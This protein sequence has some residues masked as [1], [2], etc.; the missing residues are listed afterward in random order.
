M[1]K[2]NLTLSMFA[3]A[4]SVA[5]AQTKS[6]TFK[7]LAAKGTNQ[8]FT[9]GQWSNVTSG[10]V[11]ISGEKVKVA[12]GGYVGL[13]HSSGKTMELKTAG[14]FN[15]ADLESKVIQSK[16]NFGEKYGDFVA[17][18]MFASNPNASSNFKN[19]G[20]ATRGVDAPIFVYAPIQIK[21]IKSEPLTLHWNNCGGNHTFSV[22]LTD[23]FGD[24][25]YST[26]TTTNSATID[27]KTLKL[28]TS[29]QMSDTQQ[30]FLLTIQS[31]NDPSYTSSSTAADAKK[32]Q[33][34]T[35]ELM[36]E[37]KE[38]S[39]TTA[40]TK[41]KSQLDPKSAMDY[42]VLAMEYERQ[43]LMTYA[44]DS[45]SKAKNLAPNI[46]EFSKQYEDYI[47]TKLGT[48]TLNGIKGN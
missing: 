6:Y 40:I 31:L 16:S 39:A 2:I 9:K 41:I 15:I 27:F 25:I 23:Y 3:I 18:G 36:D 8:L 46:D 34:Y 7:V 20:S 11:L 1:R 45:Y 24:Q 14:T 10:A 4:M 22:I 44:V 26:K 17:D 21:A 19:T 32:G 5:F 38:K 29:D 33:S 35:I 43:D 30:S 13:I 12:D 48:K 42:L 47:K 28:N 37:S